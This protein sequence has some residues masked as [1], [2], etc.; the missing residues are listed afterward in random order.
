MFQCWAQVGCD[1]M[2][3][4]HAVITAY[5]YLPIDS[6]GMSEWFR[7]GSVAGTNGDSETRLKAVSLNLHEPKD[8]SNSLRTIES[9]NHFVFPSHIECFNF[10]WLAYTW[11]GKSM[12][13][14]LPEF[15]NFKA[16]SHVKDSETDTN[17]L[18]IECSDR[19]I[20]AFKGTTSTKNKKT[21]LRIMTGPLL[22]ALPTYSSAH[23]GLF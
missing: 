6:F 16:R 11:Q 13:G 17:A 23:D 5:V 1:L 3:A 9:S 21:D 12:A 7:S 10:S 14:I 2:L 20:L 19:I 8:E 22:G 18:V 15:I 4:A